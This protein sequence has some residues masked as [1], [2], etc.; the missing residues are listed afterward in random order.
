[1]KRILIGGVFIAGGIWLINKLSKKVKSDVEVP[2]FDYINQQDGVTFMVNGKEIYI[3]MEQLEETYQHLITIRDNERWNT[4]T[5]SNKDIRESFENMTPE[6]LEKMKNS[7]VF[8]QLSKFKPYQIDTTAINN[9]GKLNGQIPSFGFSQEQLKALISQTA[10]V[11]K[12]PNY[13]K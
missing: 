8:Q 4:Y 10:V 9:L 2:E 1:M 3:P 7:P 11:P 5:I 12:L 13:G 6:E